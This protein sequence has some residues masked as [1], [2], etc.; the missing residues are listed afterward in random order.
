[1]KTK[2]HKAYRSA[3]SF[4]ERILKDPEVRVLYEEEHAK[5][6]I[7]N[8]VRSARLKAGLTQLELAKKIGSVQSV[9]ARLESGSDKRTPSLPLL[10]RIA[11]ACGAEFEFGFRF[12]RTG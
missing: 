11:A 12:K 2:K 8:A 7:A 10:A 4:F 6:E 9:V 3:K 1:M 5:T